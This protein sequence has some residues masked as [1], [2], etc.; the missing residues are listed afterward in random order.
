MA[1]AADLAE[2]QRV[3]GEAMN[4]PQAEEE[5]PDAVLQLTCQTCDQCKRDKDPIAHMGCTRGDNT[6]DHVLFRRNHSAR[7]R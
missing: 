2:I 1:F 4:V 5:A 6:C 7:I 3:I